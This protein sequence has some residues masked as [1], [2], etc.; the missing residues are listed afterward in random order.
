VVSTIND[1]E[2]EKD[3]IGDDYMRDHKLK[4]LRFPDREVFES[5]E[6][7]FPKGDSICR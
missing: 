2:I 4:V 1:E 6:S 3:N 5:L 7:P